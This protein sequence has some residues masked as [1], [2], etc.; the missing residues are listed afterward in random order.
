MGI[1]GFGGLFSWPLS[2]VI[3]RVQVDG[4]CDYDEDQVVL[5]I[6]YLTA[7]GSWVPVT[8]DTP[9]INQIIN[10]IK[11]SKID[12]LLASL[13]GFGISH[14]LACHQTELFIRSEAA[15]ATKTMDP[16]DLNEAVKMRE[17]RDRCFFAPNHTWPNWNHVLGKQH[18]CNDAHPE[19]GDGP[20]LPHGLS[21]M[22]IYT[23]VTPGSKQ[24]AVI[25]K[26]LMAILI[27]IAKSMKVA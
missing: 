20:N 16:T 14:L 12:E 2:Y 4:M 1:N 13:N 15:A 9:T 25:V 8:L 21:I 26:N 10:M 24:V 18:A 11:E 17:G 23:K 6:P 7:F 3:I 22:N 27:T 5:V 19:G